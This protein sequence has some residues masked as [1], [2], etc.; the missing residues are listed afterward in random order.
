MLLIV[1]LA[2]GLAE[3]PQG[4]LLLPVQVPGRFDINSHILV[5]PAPAVELRNTLAL[6]PEGSAGL[7]ALRQVILHLAVN[8]GDL[9]LRTQ[10]CLRKGDGRLTEDGGTLP[11]E[12]LVGPDRNGDE[13]IT[14]RA[15]VLSGVALPPDGDGLAIVDTCRD[16]GLNGTALAL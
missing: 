7:G 16:L 8:G 3:F 9:Q 14:G 10:N 1:A 2:Q 4:V 13:Q 6:Q 15:A 5:T 11:A 12:Q